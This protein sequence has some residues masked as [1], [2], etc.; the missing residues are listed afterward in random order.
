M[1]RPMFEE[2]KDS[3]NTGDYILARQLL[4]KL[5]EEAK[6]FAEYWILNAAI[7]SAENLPEHAYICISA[8]IS[9]APDNYELYFMLGNYYAGLNANQAWLCYEQALLYCT[10]E[11]DRQ[12][13][14]NEMDCLKQTGLVIVQ[15]VSFVIL[16]YNAM[17]MMKECIETIRETMLKDT[18]E[19]V[20]VDNASTDG[21]RDWLQSQQDIVLICNNENSGF[22]KGC[23]QGIHAA[24]SSH[25][26]L[27]LNNDT[28][29]TPNAVFWLRMGLYEKEDV[30]VTGPLSNYATN[31]TVVIPDQTLRGYMEYARKIQIPEQNP[32]ENKFWLSGFA[33][34]IKRTALNEVGLLDENYAFANYEDSDYGIRMVKAGYKQFLCHNSFIFHWGSVSQK[35]HPDKYRESMEKN[36][37]YFKDKWGFNLAYYSNVRS[38]LIHYIN[39][40]KEDAIS[41]LEIGCGCGATLS[42]IKYL[43]PNASVHG[44]E[45]MENVADLGRY[46]AD[47]ING[48]IE[49]MILPYDAN[50]FDYMIMGDVLEHLRDPE[51]AIRRL[52]K[53]LKPGGKI[54]ASIPNLM[55]ISVIAPLLQGDFTYQDEGLLDRTHIH[56]FTKNEIIRMFSRLDFHVANIAAT[57]CNTEENKVDEDFKNAILALPQIADKEQFR[58]YQYLVVAEQNS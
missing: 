36:G 2:V 22:A 13:I 49:S 51:D 12:F 27:L 52:K 9:C 14:I 57:L 42:H 43:Y 58:I 21:I 18:Y 30:G 53:F 25:D 40:E 4:K 17:D 55:H 45:L 28:L 38:E 37:Q 8:G 29:L 19:I 11:N 46:M 20:V 34:L 31:Q 35:K 54:I 7:Y 50:Q 16:S 47:V 41:V 32:Y 33:M 39:A 10:D 44:V 1:Y 5:P 24:N 15:P 23:N 48:D 3:V 56:F 6:D 26:V